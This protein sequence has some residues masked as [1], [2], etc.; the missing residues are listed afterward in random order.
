VNSGR[1]MEIYPL[2]RNMVIGGLFKYMAI[3]R[4]DK[5]GF[6]S[7]EMSLEDVFKHLNTSKQN[8]RAN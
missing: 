6:I 8:N 3:K 2:S 4:K 5:P 1:D 7:V